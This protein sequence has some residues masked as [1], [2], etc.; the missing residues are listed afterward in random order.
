MM[1][2]ARA[3]TPGPMFAFGLPKDLQPSLFECADGVW[4]HL[5]RCADTDSPLMV[6]ALAD[7]GDDGV[8]EANAAFTGLNTPGYPNFG[9]NQVAF[10]THPSQQWLDDFWAHDIPAQAAAPYGAI[11]ADEQARRNGYV[12]EVVDPG[13]GRIVQAGT[14]FSTVPPSRVTRP[15]PALGEHTEEVLDAAPAWP[16]D[17]AAA[18][19]TDAADPSDPSASERVRSPL[20]GLKV[21]DFG[22]FLAGPLGPMLLADLGADVVK[23]E[24][25]TGDQMRPVQRVFASCQRGQAGRGL[26]PQ[27]AGRPSGPRGP[28]PLGRRGPPQPAHARRPP[29]RARLRLD[30]GHQPRSRLLPRQLLRARGRTGRLARVRPAVPGRRRLGGA[31][32]RRGERS[33]VVPVRVHGPPLCHGLGRGHAP[34]RVAPGPDRARPAGDWLAPRRRRA[35]QQRDVPQRWRPGRVGGTAR[36]RADG[37]FTRLPALPLGRR[38]DCPLCPGRRRACRRLRDARRCGARRHRGPSGRPAVRGR[39]AGPRCRAAC[40]AS[41]SDSIRA[42]PFSTTS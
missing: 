21:L 3:E 18:W 11:L 5:M 35:D 31:R 27:V 2:W 33:D 26:G 25:A 6:R 37:A 14:P 7:L 38:V 1:H 13:R 20:Q 8:A 39:P 23:V 17:S 10:R 42:R 41:R 16:T 32:W 22:N 30:A 34:G 29:P 24:A 40:P 9:A 4:V 19:P 28:G 15:A 36:P 12:T